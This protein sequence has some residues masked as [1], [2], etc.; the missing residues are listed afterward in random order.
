MLL[1]EALNASQI[2]AARG[3]DTTGKCVVSVANYGGQL[4]WMPGWGGNWSNAWVEVPAD[5]MEKLKP[6]DFKPTGPPP[7]LTDFELAKEIYAED[8]ELPEVQSD[9]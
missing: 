8:D 3:Y 6:L 7:P 5:D 4:M 1:E 2:H 9:E